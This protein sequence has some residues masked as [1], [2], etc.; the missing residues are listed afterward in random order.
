MYEIATAVKEH[1]ISTAKRN[2][3]I[4][5]L[6]LW[7]GPLKI[8]YFAER[9]IEELKKTF[10]IREELVDLIRA[11]PKVLRAL[12]RPDSFETK[13]FKQLGAIMPE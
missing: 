4:K 13:I 9:R 3:C 11:P 7:N 6:D 12:R 2:V 8:P 1:G 5:A 10:I